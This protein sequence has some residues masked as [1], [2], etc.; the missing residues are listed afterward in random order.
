MLCRDA[1]AS[2]YV[3]KVRGEIIEYFHVVAENVTVVY[4]TDCLG[5]QGEFF[6]NNPHDVKESD[7]HAL[8]FAL[9]LCRLS[10]SQ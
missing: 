9:H 6:V 4:G 5:C 1:T 2:T 10:R 7:E 8:D 3:P